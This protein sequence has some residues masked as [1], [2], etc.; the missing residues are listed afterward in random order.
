ML[1]DVCE[2]EGY[3]SGSNAEP[4]SVYTDAEDILYKFEQ[5]IK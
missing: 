1:M 5:I 2:M 3:A 4:Y